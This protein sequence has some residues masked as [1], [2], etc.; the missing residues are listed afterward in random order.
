MKKKQLKV[1][2]KLRSLSQ[3]IEYR[4]GCARPRTVCALFFHRVS[5]VQWDKE[6]SSFLYRFHTVH[7]PWARTAIKCVFLHYPSKR[8]KYGII[9]SLFTV[10]PVCLT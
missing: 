3:G 4:R 5:A 9:C 1:S 10:I 7:N 2:I 8:R 6:Q